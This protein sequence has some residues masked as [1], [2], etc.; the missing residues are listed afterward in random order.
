[1][2]LPLVRT[3]GRLEASWL[4]CPQDDSYGLMLS[5]THQ[6]TKA[7]L[8]RNGNII[9]EEP[10]DDGAAGSL[11]TGVEDTFDEG[12][13]LDLSPIKLAH[14]ETMDVPEGFEVPNDH[15]GSSFGNCNEMIDDTFHY[16][17]QVKAEA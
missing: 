9:P 2:T 11:G 10:K 6:Y 16:R 5:S 15:S 7:L 1:M 13:S 17:R 3:G 4:Q 8:S 12:N 14:D